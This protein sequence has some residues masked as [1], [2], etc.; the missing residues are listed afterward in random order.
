[1]KN[2]CAVIQ[3]TR[4]EGGP[5][6][7]A[8]YDAVSLDVPA[9]VS[10]IPVNREVDTAAIEFFPAGDAVALAGKMK[11]RLLTPHSRA[12]SGDL[13]FMGQRRRAAC[14]AMLW[15]AMNALP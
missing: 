1:M 4:F 6:G 15:Q 13:I 2:A 7:G 9:I 8:V 12:F 14:G 11:T 5:G 3:P 10:D